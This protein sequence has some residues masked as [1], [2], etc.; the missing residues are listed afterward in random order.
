M[1]ATY[2]G[3]SLL[4]VLVGFGPFGLG[5]D[6]TPLPFRTTTVPFDSTRAAVGYQPVGIKPSTR[7][8]SCDTSITAATLASEH[9]TYRRLPSGLSARPDG[10]MPSGCRAVMETLML[11]ARLISLLAVRPTAYTL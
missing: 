4:G 1:R 2:P 3:P 5:Y 10:V 8:R 7:L 9:A 11:S 6:R